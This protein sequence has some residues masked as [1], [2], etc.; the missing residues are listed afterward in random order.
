[1]EFFFFTT[2][3][4]K[5]SKVP[6]IKYAERIER[7]KRTEQRRRKRG[8]NRVVSNGEKSNDVVIFAIL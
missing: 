6:Q 8:G 5:R 3:Q 1:M 4:K 7:V 2:I